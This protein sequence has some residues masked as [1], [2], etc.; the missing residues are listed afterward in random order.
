LDQASGRIAEPGQAGGKQFLFPASMSSW[1]EAPAPG[2]PSINPGPAGTPGAAGPGGPA[3][4][5]GPAFSP[6]A[7]SRSA[8]LRARSRYWAPTYQAPAR[9][10]AMSMPSPANPSN[11]T[12]RS[13]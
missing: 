5:T 4:P 12:G 10:P 11:S 6:C 8:A 7:R 3:G 13:L 1:A 9:A 2:M